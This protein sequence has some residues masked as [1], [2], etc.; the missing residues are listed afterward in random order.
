MRM[1]DLLAVMNPGIEPEDMKLHLATPGRDNR[2][3][4]EVYREG[5]FHDWQSWQTRKN[6]ERPFVISLISL[7]PREGDMWLFAG[8][9]KTHGSKPRYNSEMGMTYHYYRLTEE[10]EYNELN[11]RLVVTFASPGRYAYLNT[12]KWVDRIDLREIY[13]T[14]MGENPA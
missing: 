9:Y 6:F 8:V 4:I 10:E 11:G 3:P 1:I 5:D 12:E 14:P 7:P 13:A 2:E